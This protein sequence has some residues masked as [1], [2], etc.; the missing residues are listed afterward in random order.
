M[1]SP[2]RVPNSSI[3]IIAGRRPWF[4][5]VRVF[6][7]KFVY[8]LCIYFHNSVSASEFRTLAN[9][10]HGTLEKKMHNET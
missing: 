6:H 9:L 3:V 7:I 5:P 10:Q 1:Q 4:F 8:L 2:I